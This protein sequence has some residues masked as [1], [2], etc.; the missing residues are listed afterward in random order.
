MLRT[1]R[2]HLKWLG[3]LALGIGAFRL[4]LRLSGPVFGIVSA[5]SM[6]QSGLFCYAREDVRETWFSIVMEESF[7]ER[8]L[9][10]TGYLETGVPEPDDTHSG[11][12]GILIYDGKKSVLYVRSPEGNEEVSAGL[13]EGILGGGEQLGQTEGNAAVIAGNLSFADLRSKY[14]VVDPST[15]FPEGIVDAKTLL[16]TDFRMEKSEEPQILIFHT[17]SSEAYADSRPGESADTV[18]GVGEYLTE[19]LEAKGYRVI[20]DTSRYDVKDGAVNR[21]VSYSQALKGLKRTLTEHPGI[22]V[23]IDLHRDSGEA[24]VTTV[25][26]KRTAQI[27]LF[28][29]LSRTAE[30]PIDYLPNE[31]LPLNLAFSLQCK[32]IG[33]AKY[34]GFL[35]RNYLKSYRYNMHLRARDLLMEVGT[36]KNTVAEAYAAMEPFSE[37]LDSILSGGGT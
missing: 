5:L 36:G 26:G 20:H 15:S 8:S 24:R 6:A 23:V 9:K 7:Q 25:D 13:T 16:T 17:H 18:V 27:M 30:G 11:E 29:G 3:G 2:S 35:K 31:N 34:P 21:N 28:N 33:D 32:L 22:Q 4:L 1:H 10:N 37:I 19:L 14:F 12:E